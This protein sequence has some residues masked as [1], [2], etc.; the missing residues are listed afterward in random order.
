MVA[1]TVDVPQGLP[2][3]AFTTTSPRTPIRITMIAS[4][5][6]SAAVPPIGPISSRMIWPRLLPLRRIEPTRI[7]KSCTAPP[8][9][10]PTRM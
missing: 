6:T 7:V 8:S 4:T 10:T 9:T 1:A 3:M 2:N 5:P